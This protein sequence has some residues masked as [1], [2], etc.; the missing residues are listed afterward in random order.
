MRP[1]ENWA[2]DICLTIQTRKRLVRSI[3]ETGERYGL[4]YALRTCETLKRPSRPRMRSILASVTVTMLS[5]S[6]RP[7]LSIIAANRMNVARF[8]P[9]P[10][11]S[12]AWEVSMQSREL[13][14]IRLLQA[15]ASPFKS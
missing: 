2:F 7:R 6:K 13:S 4:T 9:L 12:A 15:G 5:A 11:A 1:G 14:E 10:A 3:E 8:R